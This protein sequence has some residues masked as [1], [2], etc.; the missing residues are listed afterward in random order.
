MF[1]WCQV[2]AGV[3]SCMMLPPVAT[4]HYV[5]IGLII[6]GMDIIGDVCESYVKRLGDVKDSG[7]FFA[8]H[9]GICD[10][11]DSFYFVAPV[12]IYYLKFIILSD[13]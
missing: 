3:F 8:G 2:Q 11:F 6:A 7:T 5:A 4:V 9:G 12:T 13:W 1:K 10:R